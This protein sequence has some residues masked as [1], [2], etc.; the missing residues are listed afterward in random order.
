MLHDG[1][2]V[3]VSENRYETNGILGTA[4]ILAD[5][6]YQRDDA[7]FMHKPYARTQC[8]PIPTPFEKCDSV[9]S[10]R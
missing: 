8:R 5:N 7:D 1:P 4:Q 3:T 2:L 6:E 9:A 10:C